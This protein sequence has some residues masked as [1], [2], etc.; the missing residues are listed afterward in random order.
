MNSDN[1]M[2]NVCRGIS[3][4]LKI[5]KMLKEQ[6]GIISIF[7][8]REH[9]KWKKAYK[10]QSAKTKWMNYDRNLVSLGEKLGSW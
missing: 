3:S 4:E 5:L 10:L 7:V 9:S 6:F 2:S 8:G 1:S